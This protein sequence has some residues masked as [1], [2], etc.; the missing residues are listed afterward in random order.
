V[1]APGGYTRDYFGTPWFG[2]FENR[3][4]STMPRNVGVAEGLIDAAGNV[5]PE[6]A[7]QG[8]TKATKPDGT[9]GYYQWL[10]GTSMASPHAAGV[11]ALIVSQYGNYNVRGD[12]TLNPDR[13][14]RVLQS[15]AF[16]TPCPTPRTVDYIKE[17]RTAEWTATCE[18][19][20]NFNGFYGHGQVDAWAAVTRGAEF[21]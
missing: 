16:K 20:Q 21:L 3:I 2:T 14:E 18:G 1:S 8:V 17:G 13:V 4:M 11:A 7:A 12:V 15:T 6:A 9:A 10:Q 5:T 19:D